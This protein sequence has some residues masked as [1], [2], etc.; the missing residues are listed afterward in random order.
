MRSSWLI[1]KNR[2][3]TCW[4]RPATHTQIEVKLVAYSCVPEVWEVVQGWPLP[5]GD[6]EK[7]LLVGQLETIQM[8]PGED[9]KLFL[10]RLDELVNTMRV[11]GIDKSEGEIVQTIGRQVSDDY[12]VEKCSSLF[13]SDIPLTHRMPTA[14][15]RKDLTKIDKKMSRTT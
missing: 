12:D 2:G 13:L 1:T 10:A 9:P 8:F 5:T 7:A 3:D 6:A 11:V 14:K 15:W 4:R